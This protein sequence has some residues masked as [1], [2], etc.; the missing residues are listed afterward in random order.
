[1]EDNGNKAFAFITLIPG[2]IVTE[3]DI[4]DALKERGIV[5]GIKADAISDM[6]KKR[7]M[8]EKILIAEGT[9][10]KNGKDGWFEFFVRLDL[11]RIPAPLPDG[12][13]DYANYRSFRNGG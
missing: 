10:A 11:P 6:V 1:M 9:H 8:N 2:N 4:Y 5:I 3:A 13:V 12:G 7:R